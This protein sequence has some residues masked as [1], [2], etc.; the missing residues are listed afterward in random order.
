MCVCIDH[1]SSPNRKR[2]SWS[3]RA[4]LISFGA[5]GDQSGFRCRMTTSESDRPPPPRP[6]TRVA[7]WTVKGKRSRQIQ[8]HLAD[9]KMV[10][11]RHLLSMYGSYLHGY[12]SYFIFP[13]K[14]YI[15]DFHSLLNPLMKHQL[16]MVHRQKLTLAQF[17]IL[18]RATTDQFLSMGLELHLQ[19]C[20]PI[21]QKKLLLFQG[22][23]VLGQNNIN[24]SWKRKLT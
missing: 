2:G 8:L 6:G 23:Q 21:H 20:N 16:E 14:K 19:L 17:W 7:I 4:C 10:L 15:I 13:C 24:T 22:S 11:C 9:R 3:L 18:L 5:C 1:C 12:G